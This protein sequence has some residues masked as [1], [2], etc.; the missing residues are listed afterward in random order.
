[1]AEKKEYID[2][3]LTSMPTMAYHYALRYTD[4]KTPVRTG[5]RHGKDI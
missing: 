5:Y 3:L 4:D 1:M 2:I